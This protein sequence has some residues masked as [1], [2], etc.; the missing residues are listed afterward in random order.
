L[1]EYLD[2]M[3]RSLCV[4]AAHVISVAWT[5]ACVHVPTVT[6]R[7]EL[8]NA[9]EAVSHGEHATIQVIDDPESG[10]KVAFDLAPD[11]RI[12]VTVAGKPLT[13]TLA[14]FYA[15]C[16]HDDGPC[17]LDESAWIVVARTRQPNPAVPR[18]IVGG[19]ITAGL[20]V[21]M[22]ACDR[23]WNYAAGGTLVGLALIALVVH[24]LRDTSLPIGR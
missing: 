12:E 5:S 7:S 20:G 2:A 3:K 24:E 4:S 15:R 23:P 11:Q 8:D 17:D 19:A 16:Q 21:C 18:Y 9:R 14:N 10:K 6:Y 13:I 1:A 22:I